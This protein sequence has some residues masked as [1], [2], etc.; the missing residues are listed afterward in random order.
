MSSV[1]GVAFEDEE[2]DDVDGAA[3]AEEDE[4]DVDGEGISI[5]YGK[6]SVLR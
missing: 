3:V 1:A 6:I 4:E 2:E 5:L